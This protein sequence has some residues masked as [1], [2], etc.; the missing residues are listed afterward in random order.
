M[1]V[2]LFDV[3][4]C[5][6]SPNPIE[7]GRGDPELFG[8][9]LSAAIGVKSRSNLAHLVS[10]QFCPSLVARLVERIRPSAIV[11]AI[12]TV[13]I[14]SFKRIRSAAALFTTFAFAK[15]TRGWAISHV[16]REVLERLPTSTYRDTSSTIIMP[17]PVIG[18]AAPFKHR[19]PHSIESRRFAPGRCAVRRESALRRNPTIAPTRYGSSALQVC[20]MYDVN[21]P[22]VAATSPSYLSVAAV[23]L[24]KDR[25]MSKPSS[26]QIANVC[27]VVGIDSVHPNIWG[28]RA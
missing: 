18:I 3:P 7:H 6:S 17:L 22:T 2:A 20:P 21:V 25:E 24:S 11:R 26:R 10:I 27:H 19:G 12:W 9:V 15:V 16:G 8:D 13:A 28:T 14:D 4:P 5:S 23:L 1:P